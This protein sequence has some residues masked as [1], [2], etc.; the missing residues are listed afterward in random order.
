V[1]IKVAKNPKFVGVGP[2]GA[3]EAAANP[4]PI[5]NDVETGIGA[6]GYNQDVDYFG[7][8]VLMR[9]SVFHRLTL[10]LSREQARSVDFIKEKVAEGK[11]FGAPT[12]YIDIPDGWEDGDFSEPAVV[13]GHEGRN[14][15]YASKELYGDDDA[16]ETH[17][18]PRGGHRN[19]HITTGW[20][21]RV[22][23]GLV[24]ERRRGYAQAPHRVWTRP[25][26]ADET[27]GPL[28]EKV[29]NAQSGR[30]SGHTFARNHGV[31][32]ESRSMPKVRAAFDECFD[33]VEEQFP[34]VGTI[35]LHED[36]RAG[37]DNGRGSERQFGYCKDGK[38]I[39]IAFAA[40]TE[41]LPV[42]NIRGL[43]AHEF[44][45]ALDYRYGDKLGRMLGQRLPTGVERRADVIAQAVFG[46]TI[47]YDSKDIQCVACDGVSPRPRRLGP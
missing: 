10:A 7:L 21:E 38:N 40:K 9:P 6:T 35:E 28:F 44:G 47:R 11:G 45:H 29:L 46:R 12:L 1:Q 5:D 31:R 36:E 15:M 43:V 26:S 20:I 41:K 13:N 19:R 24:S 18:L 34:G 17:I 8:R 25:T 39:I 37:A 16:V 42:A 33:L 3:I 2:S 14:R 4:L 32:V 22:N 27:K 30:R 23:R